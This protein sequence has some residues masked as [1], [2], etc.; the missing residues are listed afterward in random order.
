MV[1]FAKLREPFPPEKIEW[2]VG[3][4][5]KDG[6]RGMALAYIDARTVQDRL[7]EVCG[8]DG[9]QNHYSH[10][11]EMV[12]CEIGIRVGDQWIWKADGAGKTD[13][14]AEKGGLSD[15]FK[16]AAVKWGVGRYLYDLPAPWVELERGGKRIAEHELERL[17]ETL[18]TGSPPPG[19]PKISGADL[20]SAEDVE[21]AVRMLSARAEA[22]GSEDE[23][24]AIWDKDV[25]PR[26]DKITLVNAAARLRV[27]QAF[28]ARKLALQ[29]KAAAASASA[30]P[31]HAALPMT[32][33]GG[34]RPDGSTDW[35]H[36]YTDMVEL[37]HQNPGRVDEIVRDNAAMLAG[38]EIAD[39]ARHAR[40]LE[41][42]EAAKRRGPG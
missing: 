37:A 12:V 5:T 35:D 38:F 33:P 11:G 8:P 21:K 3:S 4:T 6:A 1:D 20:P 39:R 23:L 28:T 25:A 27:Q 34:V 40:L 7:D 17:E 29:G 10:V 41:L 9:W 14:E 15:A 31:R 42:L 13:F 2:R 22:A 18:R 24:L 16:R 30:A 36:W 19:R 26:L 32:V